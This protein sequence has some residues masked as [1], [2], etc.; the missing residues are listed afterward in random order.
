MTKDNETGEIF[1]Y[2]KLLSCLLHHKHIIVNTTCFIYQ[3]APRYDVTL[4][5]DRT[6]NV[7]ATIRAYATKATRARLVSSSVAQTLTTAAVTAHA[8]V[9]TRV[10]A[11]KDGAVIAVMSLHAVA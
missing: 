5:A 2:D 10:A 8:V 4:T 9:R 11:T 1:I 7:S 6:A 3:I